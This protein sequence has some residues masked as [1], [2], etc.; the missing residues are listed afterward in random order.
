MID[1]F[2]WT[3]PPGYPRAPGWKEETTSKEAAKAMGINA[4][5]LREDILTLYRAAWPAGMTADEAAAKV[6][7]SVF[8]VRPRIT[9]LRKLEQLY[10]ALLKDGA[11]LRRPNES[12]MMAT[13][14]VCRR[15]Q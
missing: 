4:Y 14:L 8:A 12:G 11:K 7:R 5:R 15:P 6:G 1:L 13:V 10:P 2:D 3:P 9:E